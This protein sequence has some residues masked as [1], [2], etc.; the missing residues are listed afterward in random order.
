MRFDHSTRNILDD[1]RPFLLG[2]RRFHRCIEL[3]RLLLIDIAVY[4]DPLRIR[5][6]LQFPLGSFEIPLAFE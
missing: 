1:G 5:N 4:T 6:R 3:D 2:K